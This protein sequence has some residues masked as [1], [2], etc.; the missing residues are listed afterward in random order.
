MVDQANVT[1]EVLDAFAQVSAK[2]LRY[3]ICKLD[4][5]NITLESTGP[6]DS[7]YDE[8]KAA[9]PADD[10]RYVVFDFEATKP[11]GSKLMKT[12]FVAYSPD[13]CREMAAKFAMQNY[14]ECVKSKIN[15]Q[16]EL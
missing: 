10:V 3:A 14:K 2:Q 9:L 16:R 8:M 6:R 4:G 5:A 11:D 1:E 7:G 15:C 13:D 12:C